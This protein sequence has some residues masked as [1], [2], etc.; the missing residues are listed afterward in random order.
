V[1]STVV[2]SLEDRGWI[3]TIGH[4]DAPGR[5]ALYGTTRAFLD[6]L[7]LRS[8]EEL[9]ALEEGWSEAASAILLRAG[10]SPAPEIIS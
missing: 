6:D 4:R 1:A 8:L 5:P 3:E 9:P 10:E 2:K 7:G